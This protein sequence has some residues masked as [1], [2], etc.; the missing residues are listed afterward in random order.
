M[1]NSLSPLHIFNNILCGIKLIYKRI[2]NKVRRHVLV[3]V[4]KGHRIL[5]NSNSGFVNKLIELF[6]V[7]ECIQHGKYSKIIFGDASNRAELIIR[8]F[9]IVKL[10]GFRFGRAIFYMYGRR[11]KALT[12]PLP[13]IWL[14]IAK[15]EGVNVRFVISIFLLNL[16]CLYMLFKGVID[17]VKSIMQ[18]IEALKEGRGVNLGRFV[19]F[20]D[21]SAVNLPSPKNVTSIPGIIS[22]YQRWNEGV[23]NNDFICHTVKNQ[24]EYHLGGPCLKYVPSQPSP[25]NTIFSLLRYIRWSVMAIF[26]SFVDLLRGRWWHALMLSEAS[27]MAL[28]RDAKVE[29]AQ[30]YL[31]HNSGYGYRPLWT[32]EAE[33]K[34]SRIILYFYSTN[35]EL[36]KSDK[37]SEKRAYWGYKKMSWPFYLVWDEFQADFIS[38]VVDGKKS[39]HIVGQINFN[40]SILLLPNL[41]KNSIAVFDVQPLR[42]SFYNT[43]DIEFDYYVPKISRMFLLDIYEILSKHN[44]VLVLKRKRD[45]NN[46]LHP[47]YKRLIE[48][49][50]KMPF[51]IEADTKTAPQELIANCKA[52]I[53]M[54][55][56]STGVISHLSHKPSVFYDP[57]GNLYKNDPAGHGIQLLQGKSEIVDWL[58][59]N[60]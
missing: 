4:L 36:F 44:L 2:N 46:I 22:W 39:I 37:V 14:N 20:D 57:T 21:L 13:P 23:Q 50:K 3:G 52:T 51:F 28:V 32:Y 26:I 1:A 19:Y 33:N 48:E 5:K 24:A 30:D 9:L 40:E 8:Q 42:D 12:Y 6:E 49:L 31:F 34:G 18:G 41:P 10:V 54:P 56:T 27:K 11:S 17:I 7:T 29:I 45:I 58:N 35:C 43:F 55:F 60:F 25:P 38:R 16:L 59:L 53:S 47:H 15:Q